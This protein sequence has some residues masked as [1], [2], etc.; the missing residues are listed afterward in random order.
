MNWKEWDGI[1][2]HSPIYESEFFKKDEQNL[3]E[4]RKDSFGNEYWL[5]VHKNI[6]FK[7]DTQ[8][9]FEKLIEDWVMI[10]NQ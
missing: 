7:D 8:K 3:Y 9:N 6:A 1:E 4:K 5:L 10:Q 2:L